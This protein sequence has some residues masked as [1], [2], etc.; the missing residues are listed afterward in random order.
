MEKRRRTGEGEE[1]RG[2]GGGEGEEKV[3]RREKNLVFR[4][5]G[6]P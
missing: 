4:E 5:E 6:Q 1:M 3:G 2:R